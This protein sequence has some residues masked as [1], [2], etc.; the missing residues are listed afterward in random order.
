MTDDRKL[1]FWAWGYED[2]L[3]DDEER[4]ELAARIEGMLGFPERPVMEY[5]TL[6]DIDIPDARIDVPD[7]LADFATTDRRVRASHTYGKGYR[8]LVRG[9]HGDFSKAPDVVATPREENDVE[10]VIE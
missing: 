8:D 2:K 10:A 9:F 3:P 7:R 4:R 1:S 6:A 5:P